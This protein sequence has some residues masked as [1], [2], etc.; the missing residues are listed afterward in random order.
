MIIKLLAHCSFLIQSD[1]GTKIITDPYTPG[2]L[3]FKY[4]PIN[5]SADIVT[6]SHHHGDHD[7]YKAIGGNPLVL[8]S[9]GHW[10]VKDVQIRGIRMY[11]DKLQG[12]KSGENIVFKFVLNDINVCHLGDLGH[13]LTDDQLELLGAIDILM[14]PVGGVYT[15]DAD[16]A[17]RICKDTRAKIILPMHFKTEKAGSSLAPVDVFL[18]GKEN[19]KYFNKSDMYIRKS[20]LP[21]DQQIYILQRTY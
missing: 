18:A 16:E 7:N 14:I 6:I 1:A 3:N 21:V 15:I 10:Q 4:E 5:E 19:I 2:F 13:L 11:H 17:D 12:E 9:A 8:E 20:E